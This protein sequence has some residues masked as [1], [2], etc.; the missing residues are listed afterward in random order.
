MASS[1][2]VR[3]SR[4]NSRAPALGM[5][6]VRPVMST[7]GSVWP[8]GCGTNRAVTRH[9]APPGQ[10]VK[11][12]KFVR[13]GASACLTRSANRS[14]R[15]IRLSRPLPSS[16]A[17]TVGVGSR[18]LKKRMR[19]VTG[20]PSTCIATPRSGVNQTV[21]PSRATMPSLSGPTARRMPLPGPRPM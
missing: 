15:W 10:Y 1:R 11:P 16:K 2:Q 6:V 9:D 7:I 3:P 4:S 20:L 18:S 19:P 14:P 5:F 17:M 12:V 8:A 21:S 13:E